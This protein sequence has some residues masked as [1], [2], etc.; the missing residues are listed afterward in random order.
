MDAV[1]IPYSGDD[2]Y[3]S[4][5]KLYE[6]LAMARPVIGARVGQVDETLTAPGIGLTYEP[7]DAVDLARKIRE[8]RELPDRGAAIGAAARRWVIEHRTWAGNARQIETIARCAMEMRRA[9]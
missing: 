1:V 5:L 7:L 4:P 6:A 2:S 3:F 8:V 9:S